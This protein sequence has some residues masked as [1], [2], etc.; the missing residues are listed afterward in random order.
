[1]FVCDGN[2]PDVNNRLNKVYKRKKKCIKL[3]GNKNIIL[4]SE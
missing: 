1:M 3:W 4:Q 2:S